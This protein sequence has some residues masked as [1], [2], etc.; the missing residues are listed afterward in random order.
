MVEVKF[1]LA[2]GDFFWIGLVVV[3]LGVGFGYAYG[4]ND[5][6]VMGHS[7][8]EIEGISGNGSGIV[9]GDW[10][11]SRSMGTD[12]LANTDGFVV[13][14]YH[15]AVNNGG[16]IINGYTDSNNPPTTL[17]VK[18]SAMDD[19]TARVALTNSITMPVKS[20]DYWRVDIINF[21]GS[22]TTDIVWIPLG[23]SGAG[24]AG[25][26]DLNCTTATCST[27]WSCSAA[28]P[29]GYIM[30]GG[31]GNPNTNGD[32]ILSRPSGNGWRC[33]LAAGGTCYARCCKI[34]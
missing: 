16:G 24:T 5:P 33:G 7:S 21:L 15:A 4:G 2:K 14:Y 25:S 11:H 20:G 18:A 19:G 32:L 10:D 26:D 3:L 13:A 31:G 23:G 30:T 8:G 34:N 17:M 9:L 29:S 6:A 22:G 27:G 12:Y 28:C 1:R